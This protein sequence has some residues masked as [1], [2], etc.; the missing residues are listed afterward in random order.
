M[1]IAGL[2]RN[3]LSIQADIRTEECRKAL[4][5]ATQGQPV[6]VFLHDGAPNVGQNWAQDAFSQAELVLTALKLGTRMLRK[7]A[8]FVTKIFRSKDHPAL[9]AVLTKLFTK[10]QPRPGLPTLGLTGEDCFRST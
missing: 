6:D 9:V 10:A 1:P 5:S 8:A 3:A 2:G 7:G 4:E